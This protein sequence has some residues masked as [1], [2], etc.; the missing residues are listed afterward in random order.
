MNKN[1]N[2]SNKK[3]PNTGRREFDEPSFWASNENVSSDSDA[4]NDVKK[5]VK[6]DPSKNIIETNNPNAAPVRNLKISELSIQDKDASGDRE[7]GNRKE[8]EALEAARKKEAYFKLQMEGKTAQA[9]SDLAR[10]AIIRKQREDAARKRAEEA[11][12]KSR[13]SSAKESSMTAGKSII[14]KSLGKK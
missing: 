1:K 13:P 8:R 10:L 2:R 9:K 11:E 7:P 12:A 5:Q 4:E 3:G 14:S 6:T